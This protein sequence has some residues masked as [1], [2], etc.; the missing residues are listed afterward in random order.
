MAT[1]NIETDIANFLTFADSVAISVGSV[2]PGT[3]GAAILGGAE[4]AQPVIASLST[5]L[6]APG[7]TPQS[8]VQAVLAAGLTAIMAKYGI[9]PGAVVPAA[10][11]A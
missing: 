8:V 5:A 1:T 3:Q 11:A 6:Q 2:I 7:A 10:P 4:L 9:K